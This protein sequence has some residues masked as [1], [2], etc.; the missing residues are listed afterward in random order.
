WRGDGPG[1]SCYS[2]CSSLGSWGSLAGF[3]RRVTFCGGPPSVV[4][5]RQT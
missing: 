3:G 4:R 1:R 5:T 2:W